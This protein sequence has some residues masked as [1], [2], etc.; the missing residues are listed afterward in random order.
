[1]RKKKSRA[2]KAGYVT[3]W[4]ALTGCIFAIFITSICVAFGIYTLSTE[5]M[6]AL[7]I[8]MIYLCSRAGRK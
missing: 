6:I 2:R 3:A 5:K 8:I 7:L 4:I 1:M